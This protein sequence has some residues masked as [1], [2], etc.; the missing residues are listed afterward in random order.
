[1]RGQKRS[2]LELSID[3]FLDA[4]HRLLQAYRQACPRDVTED[5]QNYQEMLRNDVRF[6]DDNSWL[7][8]KRFDR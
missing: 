2:V 6:R 8:V 4:H 3:E 7:A 1:M 5:L